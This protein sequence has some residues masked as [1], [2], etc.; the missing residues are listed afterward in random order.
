LYAKLR[1]LPYRFEVEN[2]LLRHQLNIARRHS[3][4]ASKC[5][6]PE[7][8]L[9]PTLTTDSTAQILY[10]ESYFF[11]KSARSLI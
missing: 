10:V 3:P 7:H 8:L 6:D 4:A 1:T 11:W 9:G 2:L 5:F